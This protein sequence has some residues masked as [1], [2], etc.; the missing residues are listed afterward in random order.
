MKIHV[1]RRDIEMGRRGVGTQCPVALA[2]ARALKAVGLSAYI[3]HVYRGIVVFTE[4]VGLVIDASLHAFL[5]REARAWIQRF[6]ALPSQPG[7][8]HAAD[9][10]ERMEEIEFEVVPI[11]F[12]LA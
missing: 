4:P 8:R 7:T 9:H 1:T 5:P 2:T 3:A 6:D 11:R 10:T 12:S